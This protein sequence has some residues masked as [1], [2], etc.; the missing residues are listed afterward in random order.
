MEENYLNPNVGA[1][2]QK[3]GILKNKQ[4]LS[5]EGIEI[6]GEIEKIKLKLEETRSNFDLATDEALIDCYIYEIISLNKKYQ[7]FLQLAKRNG[8][9]AKGFEK[10]G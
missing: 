3:K 10:I 8:L 6:I 2:K 9:V 1:K 4:V 7:Y 5:N